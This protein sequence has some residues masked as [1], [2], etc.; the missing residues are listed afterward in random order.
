MLILSLDNRNSFQGVLKLEGHR[1]ISLKHRETLQQG[2]W[3]N[4]ELNSAV[5]SMLI[6][7]L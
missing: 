1:G 2:L 4:T 3:P 6:F 7:K 5:Q